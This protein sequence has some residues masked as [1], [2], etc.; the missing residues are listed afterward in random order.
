MKKQG[1]SEKKCAVVQKQGKQG[2]CRK[3]RKDSKWCVHALKWRRHR[4]EM[5]QVLTASMVAARALA[6]CNPDFVTESA[7]FNVLWRRW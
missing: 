1:K 7:E 2:K 4:A 5:A 6:F 3:A